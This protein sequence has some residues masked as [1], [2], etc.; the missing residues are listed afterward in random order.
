M[1]S[2]TRGLESRIDLL[3]KTQRHT[4]RPDGDFLITCSKEELCSSFLLV[5]CLF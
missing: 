5:L 2:P 4:C 3:Q 1:D